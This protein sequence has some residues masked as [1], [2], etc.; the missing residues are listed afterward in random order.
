MQ[1]F[2][3][4]IK[5][6]QRKQEWQRKHNYLKSVNIVY[7]FLHTNICVKQYIEQKKMKFERKYNFF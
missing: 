5:Q 1:S 4:L 3:I 2:G 6:A 7:F